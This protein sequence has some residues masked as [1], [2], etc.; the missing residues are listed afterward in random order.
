ML[1]VILMIFI[2]LTAASA[3]GIP[4]SQ[5]MPRSPAGITQVVEDRA[6]R[7]S[8]WGVV[9]Q[10]GNLR[11]RETVNPDQLVIREAKHGHD[12]RGS[13]TWR[14]EQG[15]RRLVIK[16]K[17]GMGDFGSG[18]RVEVQIDRSALVGRIES[19][20]NRFVWIIDT[21]VL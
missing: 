20:N 16:F 14:V 1:K 7:V 9:I 3:L 12:L 18:N 21:D 17:P 2:S 13:M 8:C 19:A 6:G 11:F 15:G 5:R 10:L 4:Q